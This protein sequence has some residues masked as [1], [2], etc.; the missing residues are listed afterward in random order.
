MVHGELASVH[1]IAE[2]RRLKTK[3][4]TKTEEAEVEQATHRHEEESRGA[5]DAKA[6]SAL[7]GQVSE[8]ARMV[9]R[10]QRQRVSTDMEIKFQRAWVEGELEERDGS[11]G[12]TGGGD[13][14]GAG[15]SE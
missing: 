5:A 8:L 3:T 9:K 6:A 13:Q 7:Q 2:E 11:T 15:S 12:A 4:K 1:A 10:L 14:V